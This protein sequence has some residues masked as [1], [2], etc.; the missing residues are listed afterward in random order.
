[1]RLRDN[2]QIGDDEMEAEKTSTQL[3][4]GVSVIREYIKTLPGKPGVYRMMNANGN[5]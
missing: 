3:L 5:V 2:L 1:M 4:Y